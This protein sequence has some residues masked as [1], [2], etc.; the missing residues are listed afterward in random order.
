MAEA[1]KGD[2]LEEG[3]FKDQIP[4]IAQAFLGRW[5]EKLYRPLAVCLE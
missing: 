2:A 1:V 3:K 4:G 5:R